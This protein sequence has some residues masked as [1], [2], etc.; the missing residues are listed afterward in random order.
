MTMHASTKSGL[1]AEAGA[2]V[3]RRF[4]VASAR[5][6]IDEVWEYQGE[7]WFRAASDF[8]QLSLS[9]TDAIDYGVLEER[10][11]PARL[12][13]RGADILLTDGGRRER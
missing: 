13:R 11:V 12:R 7:V 5:Y 9:V 2:L 10:D 1:P 6:E 4:T 8:D 3:G